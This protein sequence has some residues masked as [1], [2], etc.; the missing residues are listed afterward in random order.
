MR[1]LLAAA[2]MLAV[3]FVIAATAPATFAEGEPDP[4][5]TSVLTTA[6]V[7]IGNYLLP[8]IRRARKETWRWERLMRVRRTQATRVAERTNDADHRRA[9]LDS[10]RDKARRRKRQA[11]NPPRLRA[12]LCIH[13]HE[14]HAQQGWATRTGNG[15]YGGLQMDLSFQRTY[16]PELL[17]T[18]GTADRWTA[19]EQI[20][21]A[22]RAYRSGR[23]FYPWPNTA[24]YCRLL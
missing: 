24:R 15:F 11:Q 20:W 10:W 5:T 17:R 2:C 18:K 22:E 12:W 9:I 14:R 13:R 21:V 3:A 1:R 7:D 4:T 23:G 19:I 16:A 6:F 8:E